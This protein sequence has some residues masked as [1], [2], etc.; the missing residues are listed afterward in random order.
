MLFE[1]LVLHSPPLNMSFGGLSS[2]GPEGAARALSKTGTP[3]T[4]LI[5]VQGMCCTMPKSKRTSTP[6]AKLSWVTR[7]AGAG[8]WTKSGVNVSRFWAMFWEDIEAAQ[9]HKWGLPKNG[10]FISW[11]IPSRNGWWLGVQIANY[12][13][14]LFPPDGGAVAAAVAAAGRR[15]CSCSCR[16]ALQEMVQHRKFWGWC[17]MMLNAGWETLSSSLV[18]HVFG[19]WIVPNCSLLTNG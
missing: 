2:T 15:P 5:Q 6:D 18:A 11:K 13:A 1:L 16:R 14:R 8:P 12:M 10:W 3:F 9:S 19:I 4:E 17:K 7:R